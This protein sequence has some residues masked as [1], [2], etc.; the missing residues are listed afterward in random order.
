[1]SEFSNLI[2][3]AFI[4]LKSK[5]DVVVTETGEKIHVK[6]PLCARVDKEIKCEP[7]GFEAI[8][9]KGVVGPREVRLKYP[10]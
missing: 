3:Y 10:K 2:P 8:Y 5:D 9:E 1:M 7:E 4:V 6:M